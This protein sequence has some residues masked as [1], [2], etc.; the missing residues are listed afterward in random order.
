MQPPS[1]I[2]LRDLLRVI[3]IGQSQEHKGLRIS[4]LALEVYAD[5]SILTILSSALKPSQ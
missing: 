4:L 1:R 5:G 2:L 3:A